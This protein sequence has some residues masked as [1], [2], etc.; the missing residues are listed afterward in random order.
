MSE[1]Q[2]SNDDVWLVALVVA[3]IVLTGWGTWYFFKPQVLDSLRWIRYAEMTI[4]A[5]FVDDD[6]TV[7]GYAHEATRNVLPQI[8]ATDIDMNQRGILNDLALGPLRIPMAVILILMGLWA[9]FRG[10]RTHHRKIYDLTGLIQEQAKTFPTI[11]PFIEFNPG[12]IEPRA[13]GDPVPSELPSFSEALGPEEWLAFHAIPM[14]D[15]TPDREELERAFTLQLGKRW[16]GWRA[17]PDHMQVL[18]ASFC[19]RASR[20]RDQSDDILGRAALCWSHKGG[21]KLTPSLLKDAR[22][23]LRTKSLS[24]ETLRNCNY[25]G[26][27]TTAML[28]ALAFAREEGG[29][30]APAQFVWLRGHDRTLWYPLNNLGRQAFHTE[31]AGAMAHYK[32]EKITKR[33]VPIPKVDAAV[34]SMVTYV[35]SDIMRPIPQLEYVGKSKGIKTLKGR[36]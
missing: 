8:N 24:Q 33:P 2:G 20:K 10:P 14:P 3:L 13:P 12:E 17:L 28:R 34:E 35:K 18:L 16:K 21:L 9:Y 25:Y 1:G 11:Q 36:G 29:V 31:A 15:G 6:Y 19:L 22:K 5:P 30:C 32:I 27:T 23:I 4:A 26:W 7:R